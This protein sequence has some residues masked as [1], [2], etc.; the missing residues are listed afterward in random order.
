MKN[1]TFL[2]VILLLAASCS[3]LQVVSDSDPS[4]DFTQYKTLEFYGWAENSDVILNPFDKSR[5]EQA[6]ANEFAKRGIS[7]V[8][9]GGDMIVSLYIVSEEKT[10]TTA[11][12]HHYGGGWGGYYGYGPGYGWGMGHSTTTY[13]DT[14]YTVG[15][16]IISVFDPNRE[17][18]IWESVGMGTVQENTRSQERVI[19]YA[20]AKIMQPYPVKP[21]RK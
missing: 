13:T 15:T 17:E 9:E 7:V 21:S 20:V 12:T 1:Y 5:I 19:N 6:F 10:K 3:S 11:H 2:L 14:Q 16:L 4:V 8:K 18:L